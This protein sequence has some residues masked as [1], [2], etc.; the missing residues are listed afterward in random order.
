MRRGQIPTSSD[1]SWSRADLL[2]LMTEEL[3]TYV[4]PELMAVREEFFVQQYD[5]TTTSS[6][7][8][9]IPPRAIGAKLRQVLQGANE[10]T[11]IVV[12]RIEP[13]QQY[14]S[15]FG[16][17]FANTGFLSGYVFQNNSIKLLGNPTAGQLLRMMYFLRPGILVEETACGLITAI[18]TG[19]K[20]VTVSDAPTTFTN[21]VLYDF[22]RGTQGFDTLAMD[23]AATVSGTNLTFSSALPDGLAVG[24]YVALATQ[25]P[26]PQV[27]IE[28]LPFLAQRTVVKVLEAIGDP[29]LPAA[30]ASLVELKNKMVS[31]IVTPRDEGT[32]RF[33]TNF[34]GPGWNGR[35]RRW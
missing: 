1:Q 21:T 24:D 10:S 2:A 31:Q 20:T 5:V 27:P 18:N 16:V 9:R 17:N 7:T 12:Q 26:I 3:Q 15:T 8:Y 30:N 28:A 34:N 4:V 33:A 23:Q 29:K 35:W 13:K 14:G 32:M 6:L 19:T 22:I 11:L 25:S